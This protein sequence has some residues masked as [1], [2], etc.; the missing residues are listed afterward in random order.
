M[1]TDLVQ[2]IKVLLVED[3]PG[4]RDLVLAYLTARGNHGQVEQAASLRE[5]FDMLTKSVFDVVLLDLGLPDSSGLETVRRLLSQ[6]PDIPVVVLTGLE[7]EHIGLEAVR[8]GAQD[9]LVKGRIGP[10]L[11]SRALCYAV[12]R[13][14]I[15]RE[16]DQ[17]REKVKREREE[18]TLQGLSASTGITARLYGRT[19]LCESSPETFRELSTEYGR[20][21]G[22]AL[23]SHVKRIPHDVS[24]ALRDLADRLGELYAGPRDV[25]DL[26][27]AALQQAEEREPPAKVQ[28]LTEEGRFLVL[29]LMGYLVSFYRSNCISFLSSS[30]REENQ[31]DRSQ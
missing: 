23:E 17:E 25:V 21:L 26:H 1:Q 12:E 3:N 5:A 14:R 30:R 15:L 11:L 20:L 10:E 4:D 7:D 16:L 13:H 27:K 18:H 19:P 9:Y 24:S 28:A 6:V 8:S 22:L 2:H 29:E 31:R